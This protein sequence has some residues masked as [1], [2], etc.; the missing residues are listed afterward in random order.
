M[1]TRSYFT[2][3]GGH[4]PQTDLLTGRAVFTEAYAVIPKGVMRDIVTS[5]LPF[6]DKTRAWV[7]ARPLSGFAETFSQYIME[8]AQGGGSDKPELDPE[9][10]GVIF[11]VGGRMELTL[12]GKTHDLA[13]GG[14][15]FIPPGTAWAVRNSS[16]EPL[17][18]HWVRKAYEKVDGIAMP[19][20]FVTSDA[21]GEAH[22]HARD[23]RQMGHDALR[24]S[25]RHPP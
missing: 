9:A 20:A 1:T 2:D 19:E 13:A 24:R 6:W 8:V 11:V 4:P 16:A 12:A 18:F 17:R 15:A 23:R 14:Y 25:V 22:R 3:L 5:C 10:E 21:G 7:I